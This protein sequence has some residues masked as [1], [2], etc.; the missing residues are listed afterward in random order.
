LVEGAMHL[1]IEAP[2]SAVIRV[3][4]S[5][6]LNTWTELTRVTNSMPVFEVEDLGARDFSRRFYRS[7][8]IAPQGQ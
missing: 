3:D 5:T 4:T 8:S 1:L 7:Q 6:D 2:V